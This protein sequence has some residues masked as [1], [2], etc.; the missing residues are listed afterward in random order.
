MATGQLATGGPAGGN[1]QHLAA[2]AQPALNYAAQVFLALHKLSCKIGKLRSAER[3]VPK[4]EYT[5]E[6]QL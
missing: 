6:C 4:E 3:G 1:N 2:P 5:K